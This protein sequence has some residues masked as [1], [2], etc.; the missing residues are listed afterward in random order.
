[1]LSDTTSSEPLK[2]L[3]VDDNETMLTRIKAIL[4]PAHHVV[5]AATDGAAALAAARLLRPDVIVLDI[6]MRGMSGLDVARCLRLAG[7]NAAI[8]FCTVHDEDDVVQAAQAAG[9]MG[10]VVKPRIV[11]DLLVAVREARAGRPFVSPH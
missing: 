4:S 10:Y 8:V 3:V 1:M 7:S 11:S 6:S 5:G 2:V 9:G